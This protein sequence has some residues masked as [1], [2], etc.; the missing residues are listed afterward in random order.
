MNTSIVWSLADN[1]FTRI[2]I[3]EQNLL[4]SLVLQEAGLESSFNILHLQHFH[5]KSS[6]PF[7]S[8]VM[9]SLLSFSLFFG[10]YFATKKRGRLLSSCKH[11]QLHES[12]AVL[13][14]TP[15]YDP[16]MAAFS[17]IS[18]KGQTISSWCFENYEFIALKRPPQSSNLSP[19]EHL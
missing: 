11:W 3:F 1:T 18:P 9:M 15:Y 4:T 16:S 5:S 12:V 6:S 19:M 7:H 14:F 17:R 10:I 13:A 2:S 8:N